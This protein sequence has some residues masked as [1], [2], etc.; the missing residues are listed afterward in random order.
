[1][2]ALDRAIILYKKILN[3]IDQIVKKEEREGRK[4]ISTLPLFRSGDFPNFIS[5]KV[6]IE[7][8]IRSYSAEGQ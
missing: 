1:M 4:F 2:F 6:H 5:G 7:G 3:L 8:T